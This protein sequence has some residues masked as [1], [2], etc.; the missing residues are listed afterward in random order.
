MLYWSTMPLN[1]ATDILIREDSRLPQ[2]SGVTPITEEQ[3]RSLA[4]DEFAMTGL[5]PGI[6]RPPTVPGRGDETASASREPWVDA[7]GYQ[8]GY[9][10]AL[11]PDKPP[12][13][14]YLPDKLGDRV[15]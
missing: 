11:H 4:L 5:W 2:L 12:V 10:R 8:V 1:P 9:L 7:N 13:L 6:R 14:A 3:I 15:A